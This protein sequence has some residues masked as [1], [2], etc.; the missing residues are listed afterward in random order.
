MKIE[1]AWGN[2]KSRTRVTA[3]LL[4]KM[5]LHH[6]QTNHC[7]SQQ[8]RLDSDILPASGNHTFRQ[9]NMFCPCVLPLLT[10]SYFY[11][12]QSSA[13]PQAPPAAPN[14]RLRL[15][16]SFAGFDRERSRQ[17]G[18]ASALGRLWLDHALEPSGGPEWMG[19]ML[20][21]GPNQ[22]ERESRNPLRTKAQECENCTT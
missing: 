18:L 19:W 6:I 14:H 21:G 16:G 5:H 12:L 4:M 7:T 22:E 13:L 3:N 8:H 15:S 10:Y 1:L 17:H 11:P 20:T 2:P 9:D